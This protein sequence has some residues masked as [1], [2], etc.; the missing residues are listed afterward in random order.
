MQRGSGGSGCT[1]ATPILVSV[2]ALSERFPGLA[3][4]LEYAADE[5][6]SA[7]EEAFVAILATAP[8]HRPASLPPM[9]RSHPPERVAA[10]RARGLAEELAVRR[11]ALA[12]SLSTRELAERLG[13]SPAAVTKRRSKGGLVA[14]LHAGDWRYPAWQLRGAELLPSVDAVWR[15][16]PEQDALSLM[17]WFTL[18]SRQLDGATPIECLRIGWA[19]RVIEAACYVGSM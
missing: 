19:D 9:V 16:L 13:V 3:T 7:V 1:V 15:A 12:D 18:P 2:T 14:F 11:E 8:R 5:D 10:A 6:R 17:R 4:L